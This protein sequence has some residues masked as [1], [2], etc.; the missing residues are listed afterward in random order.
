MPESAFSPTVSGRTE[1][2]DPNGPDLGDM[3]G[4]AAK[5]GAELRNQYV[6]EYRPSNSVHDESGAESKLDCSL[7]GAPT[8]YGL[9][10]NRLLCP[11]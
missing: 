8:T 3:A 7:P 6:P 4:R 9:R 2:Y 11:E 1:E 5:I 10:E